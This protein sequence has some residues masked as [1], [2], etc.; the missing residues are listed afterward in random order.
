MNYLYLKLVLVDGHRKFS[1][2]KTAAQQYLLN[3]QTIFRSMATE[4][5]FCN[6]QT[7]F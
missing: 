6:Y 2:Q 7:L 4:Q 5:N 3:P 1:A